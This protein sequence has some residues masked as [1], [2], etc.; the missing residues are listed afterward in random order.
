MVTP[1]L[2]CATGSIVIWRERNEMRSERWVSLL[3]NVPPPVVTVMFEVRPFSPFY[4]LPT[5]T[6]ASSACGAW[7]QARNE[8]EGDEGDQLGAPTGMPAMTI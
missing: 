4:F 8:E 1:F 3:A 6:I 5:I 7:Y 2:V